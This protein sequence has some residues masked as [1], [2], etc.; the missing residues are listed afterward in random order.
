MNYFFQVDWLRYKKSDQKLDY[1]R[2]DIKA[3]NENALNE[4]KALDRVGGDTPIALY[5]TRYIDAAPSYRLTDKCTSNVDWNGNGN[6]KQ[7]NV[8][9][10]LNYDG[11]RNILTG[12]CVEWSN[13]EFTGGSV[14]SG[15][16]PINRVAPAPLPDLT[17]EEYRWMI[18]HTIII[19]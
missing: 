2:F 8:A 13:I 1:S 14:G 15:G 16:R 17:L 9:V 18:E 10:D 6:S 5:G 12:N 7:P 11:A 3:L 19:D 4:S